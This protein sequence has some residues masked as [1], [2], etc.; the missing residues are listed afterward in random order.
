MSDQ[1]LDAF[2]NAYDRSFAY[3]LDNQLMLNWYPTRI[4]GKKKGGSLLELGVGHGYSTAQLSKYFDHHV[5][6]DGSQE[7]LDLFRKNF[8][9]PNV[10]LVQSFFEYFDTD[11]RFD[12]IVMG[13]ILEHV[14]DPSLILR[15][16]RRFLKDD[17]VL[18]VTV[19]NAE[20]LN[21]RVGFEAGLLNDMMSLSEADKKLGHQRLFTLNTISELVE[22]EGFR[23]KSAEG[24]FLKPITTGQI[25]TLGLSKEVLEGFLKVGINYPEL[26]VGLLIEAVA[27][28]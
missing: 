9:L 28:S 7:I 22:A 1:N 25:Q 4:V 12:V 23:V 6:I 8:D 2:A 21:K 19:P 15:R 11:Q 26:C 13:F 14:D 5:V 24:I 16:F 18:F 27:K 10:S 3:E 20:A 17:G